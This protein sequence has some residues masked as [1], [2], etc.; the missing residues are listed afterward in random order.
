MGRRYA[1]GL[2]PNTEP[3]HETYARLGEALLLAMETQIREGE[4][5]IAAVRE[6]IAEDQAAWERECQD[7]DIGIG[8]VLCVGFLR[9][10]SQ[11]HAELQLA[12]KI[13]DSWKDGDYGIIR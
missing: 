6:E 7:T 3:D 4:N 13:L 1:G 2:D 12:Y 10:M 11:L 8:R 5:T 9:R